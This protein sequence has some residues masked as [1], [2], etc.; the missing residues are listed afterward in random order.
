[1]TNWFSVK[2]QYTTKHVS[3]V[4][5]MIFAAFHGL[6]LMDKY[7]GCTDPSLTV[8]PKIQDGGEC[9]KLEPL[10]LL[11]HH[12]DVASVADY[13]TGCQ[14]SLGERREGTIVLLSLLLF[15]GV[16][17]L[18]TLMY[19]NRTFNKMSKSIQTTNSDSLI[20]VTHK[21]L[22]LIAIAGVLYILHIGMTVITCKEHDGS[23]INRGRL[24]MLT[25]T[26]ML[27]VAFVTLPNVFSFVQYAGDANGDVT[28]FFNSATTNRALV[29]QQPLRMIWLFGSCL[30]HIVFAICVMSATHIATKNNSKHS[31][32]IWTEIPAWVHFLLAALIL[33]QGLLTLVYWFAAS[34]KDPSDGYFKMLRGFFFDFWPWFTGSSTWILLSSF[35]V[36]GYNNDASDWVTSNEAKRLLKREAEYTDLVNLTNAIFAFG[37]LL[38]LESV[39]VEMIEHL[40]TVWKQ[41]QMRTSYPMNNK[42][43]IN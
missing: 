20:A 39:I 13:S 43:Y 3:Y 12:S 18:I 25:A 28:K 22:K 2:N 30:V 16:G 5:A 27:A 34:N 21:G 10:Y 33:A 9:L 24:N 41:K 15:V 1:M 36:A 8:S 38:I 40:S 23:D 26:L 4:L 14:L 11:H 42:M 32:I 7:D 35:A 6:Y 31:E 19:F 29:P 17:S 37:V